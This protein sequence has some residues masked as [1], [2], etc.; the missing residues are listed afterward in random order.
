ML[1]SLRRYHPIR[2]YQIRCSKDG[3][4]A[5]ATHKAWAYKNVHLIH[6]VVLR[7]LFGTVADSVA[8]DQGGVLPPDRYETVEN[9][10]VRL[11][12]I[13]TSIGADGYM[14]NY[15]GHHDDIVL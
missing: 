9:T 5:H 11:D 6:Q 8:P 13:D 2:I 7:K 3:H 15:S 1:V 12:S 14:Q 4:R 10:K